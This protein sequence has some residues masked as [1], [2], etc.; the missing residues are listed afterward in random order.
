MPLKSLAARQNGFVFPV[1]ILFDLVALASSVMA[2]L[3]ACFLPCSWL[4]GK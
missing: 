3:T 1:L 2:P 4:T